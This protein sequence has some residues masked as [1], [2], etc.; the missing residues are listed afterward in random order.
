MNFQT[1]SKSSF[2]RCLHKNMS[3]I[4]VPKRMNILVY[5]DHMIMKLLIENKFKITE[6]NVRIVLSEILV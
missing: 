4:E 5:L 2:T 1:S 6:Q 3:A